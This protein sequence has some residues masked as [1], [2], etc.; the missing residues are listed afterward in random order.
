MGCARCHDHKFDPLQQREFYEFSA[1]FNNIDERGKGFKYVNSPPFITAPTNS[2]QEQL[3]ELDGRL[4]QARVEFA[5]MEEAI[6]L[7]QEQWED[8]LLGT[9]DIDAEVDWNL[10]D[11]LVVHHPLDGDIS[12]VHAGSLAEATLE[13]GLPHFVDGRIGAAAN[14]DGERYITAGFEINSP[15]HFTL[16]TFGSSKMNLHSLPGSFQPLTRA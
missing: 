7:A 10:R 8:A 1:F 11:G 16:I 6:E 9:T 5:A 15:T 14:F 2:Q 3:D 4:A 13:N 12:G